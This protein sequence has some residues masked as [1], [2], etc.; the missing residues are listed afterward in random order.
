MTATE[1]QYFQLLRSA[2]WN[3]PVG[4]TETI[5]WQGVMDIANHHGNASLISDVA[6]RMETDNRPSSEMLGKMQTIMRSNLLH[7]MNLK[8]IVMAVMK[9]FRSNGIEPVVLKGFGLAS[10]YPNPGLRQFGD[11]DLFVGLG[12]F[13]QACALVR[14]MPG[15]YSWCI[16]G[17]VGRHYNV[18]FGRYPMEIHRVS[19]D[20][21]NP[22]EKTIYDAIEQDGL[23]ENTQTTLID[24]FPISIPSKEFMV[25]FTFYH[26]WHHLL[27]TGVG[28]RQVSDVAIALH[29][30]HRQLDLDKLGRWIADMH[31]MQPW[32]AFGF[33]MVDKLGLNKEEMPFYS[34][35]S[36]R[37]AEKLYPR[38]MREGNF[39][40]NSKFKSRKPKQRFLHKLHAFAGAFVDFFHLASIFP[41]QA[42]AELHTSLQNGIKKNI[43]SQH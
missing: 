30:Y 23:V 7:Q 19:A 25:F 37:T 6:T 17:D 22:R 28:L 3:A 15:A 10:L 18:D 4:I 26:A 27:T 1:I 34:E 35:R 36:R 13:H 38:L 2:L 41:R 20:V 21:T 24:G 14:N 29:A 40:R 9:E 5:D 12:N 11:T 42:F 43:K 32:Q 8:S 39:R 33:L 31:L 16:E